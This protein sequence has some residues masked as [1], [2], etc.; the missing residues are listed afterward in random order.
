MSIWILALIIFTIATVMTMTGRGGGNF[1][2][3]ALA[4]SG[5]GMHEVATTGQFILIM[6]SLA[7]TVLFSKQKITDWKLFFFIGSMTLVS[8]F[9][10]GLFSAVLQDKILK[11]IF[12]FFITIASVLMLKPVKKEVN[13]GGR[14]TFHLK[15]GNETYQINLLI[16]VPVVLI[17]G[18]VSGMVGI[19]GGSFLVP[20]MILAIRVP[21]HIAVGTSTSLVLVTATAG[22]FGHLSSGH[23]DYKLALPLA[24]AG[25]IG[26]VIGVKFTLKFKPKSLKIVFALTS[27]VAV[28]LMIINAYF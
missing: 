12:A 23:F 14:F 20:L 4:L 6:S 28:V 19:S 9:L 18:F 27:L 8:A 16:V 15:S 26:G 21:M 2:V 13:S 25:L 1:Y 3:L 11:L 24:A 22:F 10:G 5:I 7:A 17:S